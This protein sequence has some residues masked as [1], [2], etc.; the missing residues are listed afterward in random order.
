MS[1][2]E[3]VVFIIVLGIAFAGLTILYNQVSKTSVDPM[4]R[5]QALA[6]ASSLLEEVELQAYTVCDPDD[7]SVYT[8]T[9]PPPA[10]CA[11]FEGIGVEGG[12][13]R[14]GNPRFDNV[15][16]Y[17]NFRM[18][19]LQPDPDIKTADGTL[20]GALADYS[21]VVSVAQIAAN[22]LGASIPDTE[23]LRIRVTATHVPTGTSVTLQGY[24]V[25]YAPNSP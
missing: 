21:V 13:T 6:L 12:E 24:R 1:L 22:E 20:I 18:G 19:R 5:K 11:T 17:D 8:A 23:G 9:T 4:I 15:S 16:D 7:S 3:V 10:G 14:Y 25:R 2:I